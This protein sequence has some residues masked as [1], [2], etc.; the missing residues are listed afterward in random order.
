[1]NRLGIPKTGLQRLGEIRET[2]R[3]HLA[4][5]PTPAFPPNTNLLKG[6]LTLVQSARLNQRKEIVN[7]TKISIINTLSNSTLGIPAISAICS[8]DKQSGLR[9]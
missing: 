2:I 7:F 1:M 4:E 3:E 8:C 9:G 5:M 6:F